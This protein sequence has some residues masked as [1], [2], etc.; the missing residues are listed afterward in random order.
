M[1]SVSK[2]VRTPADIGAPAGADWLSAADKAKLD[3]LP[4]LGQWDWWH[5][6][7]FS[8]TT[9]SAG[10]LYVGAA[11]SS[12]TNTTALP[13]TNP[14]MRGYNQFGILLRSSTTTTSGYRYVTTSAASVFFGQIGLKF[15]CQATLRGVQTLTTHRIG[16]H[17]STTGG[18]AAD[19]AYFEVTNGVATFKTANSSVR[20]SNATTANLSADE[21]YTFDV[22]VNAAGTEARGR[23]YSGLTAS[24]ILDVTNT[25]NIPTTV[26]RAFGAGIVSTNT[27]TT[28]LD[29]CIL[30]MMGQGTI[31][32]F[33]R[34]RG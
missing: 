14:P 17:D 26:A 3:A 7:V 12:G 10:E 2:Y 21:S 1:T 18:D 13:T 5:E 32:G 11:I 31:N 15:R 25:T 6:H 34:A 29:L 28:A 16:F 20:T 27:G 30:H 19:G 23:I 8:N 22:E 24:P 9:S 33:N 4:A